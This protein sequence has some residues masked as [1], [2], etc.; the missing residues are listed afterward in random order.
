MQEQQAPLLEQPSKPLMRRY[1]IRA[2]TDWRK[3]VEKLGFDFHTDP[4]GYPYW[5][6]SNC[7]ELTDEMVLELDKGI[8]ELHRMCIELVEKA[9]KDD[10]ILQQ[11]QIP[12]EFWSLIKESWKKE[13][14]TLYGRFDLMFDGTGPPK[15]LEYNA[16]TPTTIMEA[17]VIQWEWKKAVFPQFVQYNTIH[18][19][20]IDTWKSMHIEGEMHFASVSFSI[21]DFRT[22]MYLLDT[23]HQAGVTGRY[24]KVEDIGWD[25]NAKCFV[26]ENKVPISNLFKLYPYEWIVREKFGQHLPSQKGTRFVEPA[27]KMI[28][29]NKGILPLL[30]EMY[31]EHPNLVPA[32]FTPH[33]SFQGSFVKKK[34]KKEKK[35]K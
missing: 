17:A 5:N 23:A 3:L 28:L 16:D 7:Y 21:E 33:E 12:P 25:N 24:I 19:K 29:S 35:K 27:W 26:N 18:E 6:E 15:L 32:Y 4:N 10:N 1:N 34:I 11:L 8:N 2:R 31:P 30:W 14:P 20:L 9:V 13:E 22:T